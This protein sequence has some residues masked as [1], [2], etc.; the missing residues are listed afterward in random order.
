MFFDRARVFSFDDL[1]NGVVIGDGT[2]TKQNLDSA[3]LAQSNC[4]EHAIFIEEE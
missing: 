3:R 4:P 1:G 2:L